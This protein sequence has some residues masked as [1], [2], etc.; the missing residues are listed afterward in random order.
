MAAE[1]N[2]RHGF[3]TDDEYAR[4][5]DALSEYLRHLF[6][7]A[8]FT[9]VRLA[10]PSQLDRF[11]DKNG[12]DRGAKLFA[13]SKTFLRALVVETYPLFSGARILAL[14]R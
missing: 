10:E 12:A 1:T 4:L 11:S 7:T 2:I 9:G 14:F 6:V 3:L 13:V 8:Y 5:R